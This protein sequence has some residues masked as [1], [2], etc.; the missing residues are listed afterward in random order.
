MMGGSVTFVNDLKEPLLILQG[1]ADIV[2]HPSQMAMMV[3]A[4]RDTDK[5]VEYHTYPGEG[6]G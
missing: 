2:C 5:D 4:L 3:E 1:E 6:H